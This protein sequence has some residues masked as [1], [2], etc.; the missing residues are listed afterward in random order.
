MAR[1]FLAGLVARARLGLPIGAPAAPAAADLYAVGNTLRYRDSVN[2]ERLLLNATDNPPFGGY[3][4]GNFVVPITGALAAG[5]TLSANQIA[6]S[7]FEVRR[8]VTF[9]DLLVRV[10]TAA[11]STFQLAIYGSANGIH[12]G[13]PIWSTTGTGLS[14]G[15]V[16]LVTATL[17]GTLQAGIYWFAINTDGAPTF[18]SVAAN[19]TYQ[20]SLVGS[21]SASEVLTATGT[22]FHCRVINQTYGTWP[23]LTGVT[24]IIPTS[25]QRRVPAFAL[26]V[27]A[28][29]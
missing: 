19:N 10:T 28:L 5:Q 3:A 4:V 26:L 21:S 17:S 7:P 24:S 2:A 1:E 23:D 25:N 8:A 27:S 13:T 29:P 12:T 14:G 15:T 16:G 20:S 22:T 6:L 18:V 11:A 9:S